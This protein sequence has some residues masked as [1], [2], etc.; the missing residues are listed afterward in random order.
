MMDLE[1]G[2]VLLVE[3]LLT[4]LFIFEALFEINEL[5]LCD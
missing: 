1:G 5:K 4:V 3:I 2:Y